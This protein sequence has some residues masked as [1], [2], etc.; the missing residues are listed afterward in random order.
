MELLIK[1]N[2]KMGP[3]VFLYNL[4][5]KKTCTPTHWCLKGRNGKPACYAL[6]NNFNLQSV[7]KAAQARLEFSKG[8]EFVGSMVQ[9]IQ[10]KKPEFFRFHSSG[11]FY[12]E[13]YARKVIQIAQQCPE[14]LFR[15]T[16]RRRD[17]TNV[18]QELNSLP[19]FI[20]RESLDSERS[21]PE[22]GLPFAALASLKIV[23]PDTDYHCL[24][25]CVKCNY[26]CWKED[27]NMYFNEF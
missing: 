15:T 19:N 21:E 3:R 17:L 11:D 27:F 1:G 16:T 13:E 5:P 26:S 6:R 20:V 2:V 24:D 12:S 25:D 14:T 9:A 10:R 18:L 22:M 4:P 23:N 7:I 8:P